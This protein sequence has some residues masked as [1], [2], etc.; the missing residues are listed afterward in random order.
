VKRYTIVYSE[1]VGNHV[2]KTC[3]DRVET[4]DLSSLLKNE[5]YDAYVHFVF[6][7]W[8]AEE[9]ERR[10]SGEDNEKGE[11]LGLIPQIINDGYQQCKTPNAFVCKDSFN[12]ISIFPMEG[13]WLGASIE[14]FE[15]D[16]APFAG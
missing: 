14:V 3:Y 15:G 6:D 7:G 16:I 10:V 13:G 8:P 9:G 4:D 12:R 5:K 2:Y 1:P 11:V